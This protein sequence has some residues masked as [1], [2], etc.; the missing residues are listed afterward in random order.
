MSDSNDAQS[1]TVP[2]DKLARTYRKMQAK[3]QQLTAAYETEVETIK[4]Q[5]DAIRTALKDQLMSL[6][7]KSVNTAEGTVILGTKTRYYTQDWDSFK[8]FI[9]EHD[10]L[11]LLEKR[12]AQ[13]NMAQF[14]EDNPKLMPPGL[15]SNSEYTISVRRPS[16]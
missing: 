8:E 12:I 4:A 5:Q 10:A 11:D 2:I 6:G 14:L 16:K 13:T 1:V 15:N 3:I 7:V 9:K